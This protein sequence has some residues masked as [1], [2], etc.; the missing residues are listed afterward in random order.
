MIRRLTFCLP[1]LGAFAPA[2]LAQVVPA[3]SIVRVPQVNVVATTP[4][5]G[6]AIGRDKLPQATHVL[7]STQIDRTG[8]PSLTDAIL[9]AVPSASISDVDGNPFQPDINFH[10][11]TASPVTGTA[12]GVAVYLDGMRFNDPFGDTVNWDLIPPE[13]IRSASLQPANPAFGLNALGGALDVT[14]KNGFTAPGGEVSVYGGSYGR[15]GGSLQYGVHRSGTAAYLAADVVHD[16]GFRQTQA[17]RLS[18][19]YA[20]L[21]WRN[22]RA[23]LHL[24]VIA[25]D[26]AIGNPGATPVQALNYDIASIFSGPNTVYNKYIAARATA[27]YA[28]NGDTAL[29]ALAYF[30]D[31]SQRLP[32]GVTQELA[33]CP[34]QPGILC[35]AGT[36][37]VVTTRGGAAVPD[38]LN[39]GIYSGLVNEGIDQ[40]GYGASVQLINDSRLLRHPNHL[41]IGASFD[42]SNTMFNAF[43]QIGG[44]TPVTH[45]F[46]GPGV[47]VD[48]PADAVNPVQVATTT[49]YFGLF[50]NDVFTLAPRLDLTL[51]GR[52]NNAEIDLAD[53]LGGPVSGHHAYDRFNPQIGLTWHALKTLD[54]YGSVDETNRNPTPTELS[55]A[56]AANPCSLLNFFVGDPS[57]KQVVAQTFEFGA[58]GHLPRFAGGALRWNVD[59]FRTDVHDDI[60]YQSTLYNPNLQFYTNSGTTRRQ[61]IEA[62]LAYAGPRLGLRLGFAHIDATFQNALTLNSPSNPAAD[63]NG[64]IHIVPGDRIPGI[65]ANRGTIDLSYKLT[66]RLL[67][68]TTAVLQSSQYRFGDEANLTKPVGGYAVFNVYASYKLTP[69]LTVFAMVDNVT[70]RSYQTY[71]GFGPVADV[72]WNFVPGGVTD[73]RTANPGRPI[74][75][76]GGVK[77]TF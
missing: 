31:L 16:A 32:N 10:G 69:R 54:L 77:M 15:V 55:C 68:G 41:T 62:D 51:A 19:V 76:Y 66:E 58:R 13:A 7:G 30:A 61:G 43:T 22:A 6:S 24:G 49:R 26:N 70:N 45:L 20:D 27:R 18:R 4:L 39:G 64:Q 28:L 42:G 50:F 14:L 37:D 74:A 73:P 57:L 21:G 17:S 52:F 75:G 29:D 5:P 33:A 56:S 67:L 3:A 40:Q 9:T 38:F 60:I 48:Q 2:A 25:A 65:P 47:T 71:G 44:I 34:G 12:E 36:S 1:L 23:E 72:P 46:I 63:A 8:I 11:F 59:L 35:N 53:K